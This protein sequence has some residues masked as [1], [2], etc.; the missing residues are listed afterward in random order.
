MYFIKVLCVC[1]DT[2]TF[3]Q[4]RILKYSMQ[5]RRR[6]VVCFAVHKLQRACKRKE[7]KSKSDAVYFLLFFLFEMVSV[8]K[9]A[10]HTHTNTQTQTKDG[11]VM[12]SVHSFAH[13]LNMHLI[14]VI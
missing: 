1:V 11:F 4:K 6:S 12:F 7:R 10:T 8:F 13:V 14:R 3:N 9:E 5:N 2:I